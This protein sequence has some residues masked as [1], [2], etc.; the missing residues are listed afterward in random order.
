MG[1]IKKA[2][3]STADQVDENI[4]EEVGKSIGNVAKGALH[5]TSF[6]LNKTSDVI[7]KTVEA[8]GNAATR[9]VEA[10]NKARLKKEV[11][12]KDYYLFVTKEN[13]EDAIYSVTDK[14]KNVKYTTLLDKKGPSSTRINVYSGPK[15]KIATIEMSF[16]S[17]KKLFSKEVRN[18]TYSFVYDGITRTADLI[19]KNN[20]A[21]FETDFNSWV[22]TGEIETSNYRIVDKENGKTV[23]NIMKKNSSASTFLIECEYDKN[24]PVVVILALMIDAAIN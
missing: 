7:N 11:G 9:L 16:S 14:K 10:N 2:V 21:Y 15:G 12:K 19:W 5:A 20:H 1:F 8:G 13:D 3:K 4:G 22:T 6:V 24:E 23:A 18:Y 17:S